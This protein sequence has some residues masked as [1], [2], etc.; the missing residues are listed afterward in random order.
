MARLVD[1]PET[2][3]KRNLDGT[4]RI[5]LVNPPVQE[6]RYHWLRWNQPMELLCLGTWL[7]KAHRGIAVR[8][9][10]MMLP[11]EEGAVPKHKV[12]DTWGNVTDEQLWHFGEPFE[13]LGE[14]LARLIQEQWIP[15]CIVISSLT[16]YWHLSVE[17]LLVKLC[18]RLGRQLR[19]RVKI[20]LYGNYP[21]FEPE[22]AEAQPDADIAMTRTVRTQGFAPDFALYLE[23]VKRLPSFFALDIED[24]HV[25]DH[26]DACLEFQG[27]WYKQ[28]AI[29]RRPTITV[30][31]FND[32]VCSPRS[33]LTQVIKFAA[34]HPSQL[35]V[36]GIAGIE[37][38]SL[39]RPRLEELKAAG[40]RSLF[41]EH[42]RLPRGIPNVE[43][44]VPLLEMLREEEHR[45]R[46]GHANRAW[47]DGAVTGFVAIGL[48]D[49]EMDALVR[50]TLVV[51]SFF[52]SVILKPYGYSPTVDAATSTERRKR[53][54]DPFQSSP[55]WFPYVGHG[56]ALTRSDYENLL[57]WQ[58]VLNMRV[59]G[60]TFDFL[61]D[62][63]VA[64]LVRDTLVAESWKPHSETR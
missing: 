32:D 59:K 30:A 15:D 58:N 45:K 22:H 41:V 17:K 12:K 31:F 55:Q 64:K 37:P 48:P 42:A 54:R 16:S 43:A 34:K 29:A 21:R 49:D 24:D 11:D 36:E 47:L 56:S 10:D 38:R 9:E 13:A 61:G 50:S 28:R 35:L 18:M 57:R 53:W 63:N 14:R 33:S 26:L 62:G 6:K 23:S 1:D 8:L 39:S 7:K 51:N 46:S 44:Y 5:L 4:C 20:V 27:A 60:T 3:F 19:R 2:W 40:F 25:Y 52:K